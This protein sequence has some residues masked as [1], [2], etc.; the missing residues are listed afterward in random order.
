MTAITSAPSRVR[1]HSALRSF[2]TEALSSAALTKAPGKYQRSF[3]SPSTGERISVR[4]AD[5]LRAAL[6]AWYDRHRRRLPWRARPGETLLLANYEHQPADTP[7]RAS[8]AI[9]VHEG[10]DAPYD[11]VDTVPELLRRR[12]LSLRAFDGAGM[13]VDAALAGVRSAPG[14]RAVRDA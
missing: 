9:Y 1:S 5:E 3:T 10:T 14:V 12:T 4:A 11:A 13:M 2:C 8:H 7:F 6:L